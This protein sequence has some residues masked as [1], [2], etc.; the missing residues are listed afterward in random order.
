VY[1]QNY[2]IGHLVAAQLQDRLRK[3]AGGIVGRKA[4]GQWLMEK[5]FRPGAREDWAAHVQTATGEALNP[6]YFVDALG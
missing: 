3:H 6:Q 2:E 1:Y 5:F 4:A